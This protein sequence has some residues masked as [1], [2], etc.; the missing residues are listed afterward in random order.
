MRNS[1]KTDG[2]TPYEGNFV[3]ILH[4]KGM[5]LPG[6]AD[7]YY[8]LVTAAWKLIHKYI[9]KYPREDS[10][11]ED[12]VNDLSD[13]RMIYPSNFTAEMCNAIFNEFDRIEHSR[14]SK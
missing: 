10:D 8:K 5:P 12:F 1:N 6:G 4:D 13:L 7:N 14:K 11:W 2:V 3:G 9:D